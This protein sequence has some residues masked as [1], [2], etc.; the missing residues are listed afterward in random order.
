[1]MLY[2][3]YGSNMSIRRLRARIASAALLSPARL[4]EHR[5]AFHKVGRKDGSGKC[6]I[7]ASASS[8]V[9]GAVFEID[10]P[11]KLILD[12]VEGLGLG[13]DE[14]VVHIELADRSKL[15][16]LTYVATATD[17]S[18]RPYDWYLRHVIEGAVET[19]LPTEYIAMLRETPSVADPDRARHERE[20]AIYEAPGRVIRGRARCDRS[21]SSR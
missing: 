2:F 8:T 20:L 17:P 3:A 7:V 4:E 6:D 1:M 12:R 18:L 16:A 21:R 15:N 10:S 11:D 13:Y 19:G 9:Y 14:R 5:L